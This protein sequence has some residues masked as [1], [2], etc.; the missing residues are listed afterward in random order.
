[1]L[2]SICL[3]FIFVFVIPNQ[4][5]KVYNYF[6]NFEKKENTNTT[7]TANKV[8]ESKNAKTIKKNETPVGRTDYANDY[9]NGRIAIWKSGFRIFKDNKFFGVGFPNILGYSKDRLPKSIMSKR[10]FEAFHN[11]YIDV[12][13]SQGI[14][15]FI[16]A[17][18]M[19]L[20]FTL[21]NI[22]KY[23][24]IKMNADSAFL[25]SILLSIIITILVSSLFVSQI[26]Y[27]NNFVT[28]I[29]WLIVGYLYTFLQN[30][31]NI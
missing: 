21:L 26:F 6:S 12:L 25:H 29:F 31:E 11:T 20:Y 18:V 22:K 8:E 2:V 3:L 10:N 7:I 28:F 9:S 19:L 1:M 27:V 24:K 4:S 16:I 5:L 14:I 15:G 13:A 23:K 30:N 17:F